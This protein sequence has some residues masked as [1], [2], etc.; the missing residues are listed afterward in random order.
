MMK[1]KITVGLIGFL[2]LLLGVWA[3]IPAPKAI[4][5]GTV[6]QG[7]FERTVQEDGKSRVRDRYLISA[8]IMGRMGRTPLNQGDVV[9][10]GDTL[11]TLWPATPALLDERTRAEQL[12]HIAAMQASWEKMQANTERANAALEQ[13]SA[14]RGRSE[15]LTKNGF[16]SPNQNEVDLL[17]VRLRE[18]ELNS[19][20]HEEAAALH[21]LAQSRVALRQFYQS[22]ETGKK[23]A[24]DIKAPVGGRVLKIYQQSEG[25]VA[26]GAPLIELGDPEQLEVVVDLLTE[27]AAQIKP[28]TPVQL[29][30]WGGPVALKGQVRLIEPAGFTKVSALG[31][32]E[33]RVNAVIDI[34][35]PLSDWRALG[36]GFKVDVRVLV[37]VVENALMVPV[38]AIFPMGSRSG[39]F[40]LDHGRAR[41]QE[42]AVK[43]R[44]GVEAWVKTDLSVGTQ[45]IIYPDTKLKDQDRVKPR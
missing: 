40:I 14:Q 22:L 42:I 37:E 7:R 21:A 32:E 12:A 19:A 34:T 18:K 2:V 13:A 25:L 11:A 45:V 28:G 3:F 43:A 9:S 29:S 17:N 39:I 38:S 20:Q 30:Q 41:L 10:T 6:S 33:Q 15:A 35:S 1:R 24:F 5:V 8:P 27:E 16:L 4:E 44:N 31:V 26:A 23:Q 36:D